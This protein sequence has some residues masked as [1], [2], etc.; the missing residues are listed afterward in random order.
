[1]VLAAG[2][3]A[4]LRREDCPD[5]SPV[6]VLFK[7]PAKITTVRAEELGQRFPA[8][9]YLGKKVRLSGWL[10]AQGFGGG[11]VELRMRVDYADGKVEFFDSVNGPVDAAESQRRMV[12]GRVGQDAVYVSIWARFHPV[13]PGGLRIHRLEL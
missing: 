2:Y 3:T 9:P 13:G 12:S 6:C 8:L 11:D 4:E 10:R 7:S 5:H 1:M